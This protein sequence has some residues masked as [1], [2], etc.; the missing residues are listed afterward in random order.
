MES[1]DRIKEILDIIKT[2]KALE[3]GRYKA[4]DFTRKS[5]LNFEN[6]CNFLIFREGKTNQMEIYNFFNKIGKSDL[7]V[8]KSALTQQREKLNP[9]IFEYMNSEYVKKIYDQI[10]IKTIPGT[11]FIPC[12]IDGSVIET[13]NTETTRNEMG[14]IQYS[15]EFEKGTARAQASGLYDSLNDI[16]IHSKIS[17]YETSEKEL[18]KQ[19][20]EYVENNLVR[21]KERIIYIFDRGY[22]STGL[23]LYLNSKNCKYLFRVNKTVYAREIKQMKTKDEMITVK[24]TKSRLNNVKENEIPTELGQELKLRVVKV[25]LDTGEE[26]ILITNIDKKYITTEKIKEIYFL[27]WK[28]ETSYDIIKNKLQIENF[29]GYS[30]KAIEQDFYA[31]ILLF[32]MAEDIK[33]EVNEEVKGKRKYEYIVNINILIG[34]AKYYLLLMSCIE[35]LERQ[36][37]LENIMLKFIKQNLVMVKSGRKN[38]RYKFGI[39]NKYKTNMKRSL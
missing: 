18:A 35:D 10:N 38:K 25:I 4:K 16:M 13:P 39:K 11:N 24:L 37:E 7:A 14:Y 30:R 26:E 17:K 33:R 1:N 22:I 34:I 31:Q 21:L 32:N 20:I 28:I 6:L 27:R 5:P 9:K 12:G 19:H 23:L 3:I 2:E 15:K 8:T 29:S 36:N